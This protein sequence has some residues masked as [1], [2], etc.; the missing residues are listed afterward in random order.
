MNNA[1]VSI[2][3]CLMLVSSLIGTGTCFAN[4]E[5]SSAKTTGASTAPDSREPQPLL[6][7]SLSVPVAVEPSLEKLDA[8]NGQLWRRAEMKLFGSMCP[9][10]LLELE[11]K[12]RSLPGIAFVK[13]TR[14]SSVGSTAHSAADNPQTHEPGVSAEQSTDVNKRAAETVVI[15]DSSSVSMDRLQQFI[16]HEKYRPA[17]VKDAEVPKQ[18]K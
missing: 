14:D 16:K 17:S 3:C 1:F 6:R 7:E 15:F 2:A 5:P 12:L 8:S 9:A 4:E 10:C 13:I 18:E 11:E